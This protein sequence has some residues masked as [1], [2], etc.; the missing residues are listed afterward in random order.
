MAFSLGSIGAPRKEIAH[1]PW[2]ERERI[3]QAASKRMFSEYGVWLGLAWGVQMTLLVV[4]PVLQLRS[5]LTEPISPDV[6]R[7]EELL[8]AAQEMTR[9][10]QFFWIVLPIQI[11]ALVSMLGSGVLACW[12]WRKAFRAQLAAEGLFCP[13]EQR[14]PS[15][16]GA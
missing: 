14:S 6:S 5:N 2:R 9:R 15:G 16:L 11:A 7:P 1:L 10:A 4:V 13:T 3:E 12:A 8:A